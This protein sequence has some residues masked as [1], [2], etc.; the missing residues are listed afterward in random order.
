MNDDLISRA[1]L[2]KEVEN[3][4]VGGAEGLKDYYENGS[5]SDENAWIGGI[6]DVWEL[7]KDAPTVSFMISPDYVTELQN[8]NK[9]LIKQ[10]EEVERPKGEW[11]RTG[12]LGNGNAHYE[13]SNCHHGDEHAESQEVPY[14]WYCGA[15]MQK[16]DAE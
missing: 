9:E 6:Y 4:V 14:C 15:K 11:I 16:G 13:C 2:K 5:K 3:L 12:S 10:L 1:A 7:I 8:H